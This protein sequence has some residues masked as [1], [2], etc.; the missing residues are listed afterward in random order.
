MGEGDRKIMVKLWIDALTPKQALFTQAMVRRAPSKAKC[1]VTARDYSELNKFLTQIKLEHISIG[2]HGGGLLVE[3]L[4]SSIERQRELVEFVSENDF[5]LSLSYLSPEAARVSFGLGIKHYVASDSPHSN[6][7]SRLAVPLS[8][9]VFTPFVI[10]KDR[11]S[12][13][14]VPADRVFRYRALDPWAWLV[15]S[16]EMLGQRRNRSVT[17]KVIIRLDEWFASYF[18]RGMGI[19]ETL[20]KLVDVIRSSGDFTILLLPRYDEQRAW[21]R[22]EF[23][24]TCTV[25]AST[26]DATSEL[27]DAD[28]LVGGGATMTQEA[29]LLGVPNMSYFPSAKLDVF[30]NYYF[31]RKLSIEADG[32]QDLLS[33]TQKLLHDI[34]RQKITFFERARRETRGFEDPVKYIFRRILLREK[35]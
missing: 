26:V 22:R 34:D 7:P 21:A 29:A 23:G 17:G 14:G 15:G 32:P 20:S 25:P 19:S 16:K 4:K 13:Y 12:Q 30:H 35:A 28:L 33:K 10:A 24:K 18:K 9:G 5:D 27:S 2:R 31:P 1:I 8:S 6:A 3:K 11:W